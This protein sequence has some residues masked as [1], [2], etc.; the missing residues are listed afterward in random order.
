MWRGDQPSGR[1]CYAA[2]ARFSLCKVGKYDINLSLSAVLAE[3]ILSAE[4]FNKPLPVPFAGI[5]VNQRKLAPPRD[6]FIQE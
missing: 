3:A 5:N 6:N 1:S 4:K 2:F